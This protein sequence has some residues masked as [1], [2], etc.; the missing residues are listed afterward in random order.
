MTVKCTV[1]RP[2]FSGLT[3]M[4]CATPS[5]RRTW[6]FPGSPVVKGPRCPAGGAGSAQWL[7]VHAALPGVQLQSLVG[8]LRSRMPR[9]IAKK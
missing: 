3:N 9:G 6:D 5:R 8:E 7:R 4:L 1:P 2:W